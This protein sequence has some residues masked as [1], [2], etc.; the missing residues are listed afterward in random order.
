[1]K[2]PLVIVCFAGPSLLSAGVFNFSD[3][4]FNPSDW[5]ADLIHN[6]TA[7]VSSYTTIQA[8]SGGSPGAWR[9]SGWHCAPPGLFC[10]AGCWI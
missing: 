4:G 7:S 1:M 3:T 5:S 8:G 2:L 9:C 6:T 10:A